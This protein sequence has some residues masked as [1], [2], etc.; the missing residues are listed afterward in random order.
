M[1][2]AEIIAL[3]FAVIVAFPSTLVIWVIVM[4]HPFRMWLDCSP[5]PLGVIVATIVSFLA[6]QFFY[7]T[8]D[9]P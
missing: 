2:E 5:W 4:T 9:L 3:S 1:T 8:I 6:Y 7:T